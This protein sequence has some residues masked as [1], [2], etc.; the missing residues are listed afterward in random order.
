MSNSAVHD[1]IHRFVDQAYAGLEQIDYYRLLGVSSAANEE[2]IRAAYYKLAAHLHPDIHGESASDSF[3]IKLTAVYS[4]VVE[5]YKV[6][7]DRSRRQNYDS[8]L[9]AGSMRLR[10]GLKLTNIPQ[11]DLIKTPAAR[12]FFDLAEHAM[13]NKDLKA[14]IMNYKLALSVEPRNEM[15]T[16]KLT[17][18]EALAGPA[19]GRR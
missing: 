12:R 3:R 15:I 6:L 5:A 18:A 10:A 7:T 19:R 14:A 16:G 13:R 1:K 9:A 2:Q 4:R 17:A 11:V 8:A